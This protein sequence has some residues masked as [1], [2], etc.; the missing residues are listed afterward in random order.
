MPRQILPGQVHF[1][2]GE[3]TAQSVAVLLSDMLEPFPTATQRYLETIDGIVVET[4]GL[5]RPGKVG[6]VVGQTQLLPPLRENYIEPGAQIGVAVEQQAFILPARGH[7][8]VDAIKAP[9]TATLL[10]NLLTIGGFFFG[11]VLLYIWMGRM[12]SEWAAFHRPQNNLVTKIGETIFS[13]KAARFSYSVI[14]FPIDIYYRIS[15]SER[16]G[17]TQGEASFAILRQGYEVV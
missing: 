17:N 6:P 11:C 15:K 9:A 5:F 12:Y 13:D 10:L 3:L 14:R 16:P 7:I 2:R 1:E 8:A 4:G